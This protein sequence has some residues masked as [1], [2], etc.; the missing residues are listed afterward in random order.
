MSLRSSIE[1]TPTTAA[2]QHQQK[3]Q[4]QQQEHTTTTVA[5]VAGQ[6]KRKSLNSKRSYSLSSSGSSTASFGATRSATSPLVTVTEKSPANQNTNTT[7]QAQGFLPFSSFSYCT[8]T[9]A[10]VHHQ[11][12]SY[13]LVQKPPSLRYQGKP[14][15]HQHQHQL[16]A[17]FSPTMTSSEPSSPLAAD[18]SASVLG[19][20]SEVPSSHCCANVKASITPLATQK[21]HRTIPSDKI[22]LRLILVSGKTKEFIFSPS[23][24]AGDI[25]QTVFDNWPEDWTHETV[26]KAE[27]LRLI[28]QGRFLHCNVTLGALGLPLGKT[29]VMHLVPR[30][31]LPEPN[32]QDQRQNSKGGSGRC[33]STN[34]SIL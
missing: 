21:M 7:T 13:A 29:T 5:I 34:C 20:S 6:Q 22:N 15:P 2:V 10:A 14:H 16:L 12:Q 4:Q 31:N 27:I 28:Y 25:A 18:G 1:K 32:S 17:N 26:A 24:S 30:D 11:R 19:P 9:I 23:D 3:Q 8:D 33:C